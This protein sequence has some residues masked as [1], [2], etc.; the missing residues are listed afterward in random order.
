MKEQIV[1]TMARAIYEDMYLEDQDAPIWRQTAELIKA[2]Y[3]ETA[4][5]ALPAAEA[6]GMVVQGWQDIA[7]APKNRKILAGYHNSLGNWRTVT[8]CYHTQLPWHDEHDWVETDGEYAPADW[9][10]E[11]ET[12]ECIRV[13]EHAPTYWQP[14]P[15]PPIQAAGGV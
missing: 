14:L 3:R 8:A 9:Y 10:E 5:A 15:T 7:S 1:E 11:S 12:H 2:D 4:Q 6:A 13:L